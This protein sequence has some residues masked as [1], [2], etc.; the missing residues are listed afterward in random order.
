MKRNKAL[1][2]F[3]FLLFL[4]TGVAGCASAGMKKPVLYSDPSNKIPADIPSQFPDRY[5]FL[6][7]KERKEFK[8]LLTDEERQ[9]FIDKFWLDRDPDPTTPEN[10]E[11]QRIDQLIDSIAS[12]PFFRVPGVFGLLF[13][14]NGGFRGDMAKVYLLHGV[15]DAVDTVEGN[16]F[17][18]LMLWVYVNENSGNIRYAFLFYQRNGIGALS[19]FSQDAYQINPCG[20]ISEI[21]KFKESHADN[22]N[23]ACPSDAEQ[24]L[25]ELQGANSK[26]GMIDGR[27]FVWSLFNFSQ[28]GSITQ[29]K[30]LQPPKP[31]SEIAKQSKA[32]IVGEAPK[33]SG[34]AGTDYILAS[35]GQCN[36]FIPGE[37]QLDKEFTLTI[38]RGDVDWRMVGD[39]Y[40]SV[41]KIMLMVESVAGQDQAPLMFERWAT[42]TSS[43]NLIVSDPAGQ[44]IIPLL[45]V[46]EVAQ[47]PAGT[48]RVSI[49]VK[50]VTPGLMTQKYNAWFKKITIQ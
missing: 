48:Y 39:R 16:S 40:E 35:C 18:D 42:L 43:K 3:V 12:E 5:Y 17:V 28:D 2:R 1:T 47:I 11:K 37:L 4:I 33:L 36:S 7:D 24:I 25:W 32:R 21:K 27:I 13:R 41:L 38:R 9:T 45:A 30:A 46:D 8:K 20:A 6:I 15:P 34:V 22:G 44:R 29:G 14:T 26:G 50:N 49:Y 10:E 19:L 31:A 23:Q